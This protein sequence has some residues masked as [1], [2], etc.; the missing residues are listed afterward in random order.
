MP[1]K[2]GLCKT[3][4]LSKG[5]GRL[6][7]N[8]TP[9]V[10]SN[11]ALYQGNGDN[12]KCKSLGLDC[13]TCIRLM[14]DVFIVESPMWQFLDYSLLY[15]SIKIT[16]LDSSIVIATNLDGLDHGQNPRRP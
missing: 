12:S 6:V 11:R 9:T 16:S 4:K 14:M 13:V 2:V 5:A 7:A 15:L 8:G 10:K 3:N 1:L